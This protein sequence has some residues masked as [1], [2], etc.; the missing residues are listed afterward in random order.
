[1][2]SWIALAV[3]LLATPAGAEPQR[4]DM[5]PFGG[6]VL[7][8][9]S[10]W[11]A[12]PQ[13]A[14]QP[15]GFAFRVEPPPGTP[16]VLFI[17]PLP[18]SEGRDPVSTARS[19]V[20]KEV[21]ERLRPSAAET[22]LTVSTLTGRATQVFYVSA[23]DKT[24][25]QP[26]ARDFKYVDQGAA[27][28]GQM[29]LTFT[30]LT[31]DRDGAARTAALDVVR[32]AMLA[33]ARPPKQSASGTV[34]LPAP[35]SPVWA[36]AIDLPG[37]RLEPI[38][39]RETPRGTK[40]SGTNPATG[41][42]VT[43]FIEESQPGQTAADHREDAWRKML[44]GTPM[45]RVDVKRSERGSMALIEYRVSEYQGVAVNQKSVNVYIVRR[46][47]WIDVHLSKVQYTP[48]DDALFEAI[49]STIRFVDP[50][51]NRS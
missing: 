44:A 7:D 12:E 38:Q 9:P 18:V 28:L 20:A 23:T 26:T 19:F 48:A 47:M 8:V 41:V 21:I 14:D 4:F 5:G 15:G 3:L 27:A 45:N 22:T 24:V 33:P 42:N 51:D 36:L 11:T 10:G 34:Q 31:N 39:I 43:A 40:L 37:F 2:R 17:T 25:T 50:R 6:L 1:M 30:V 29:M 16:L 32:T 13:D 46:G 35:T 49:I